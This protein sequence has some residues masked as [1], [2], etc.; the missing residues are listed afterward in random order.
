[1]SGYGGIIWALLPN[2]LVYY[3]V[4]DGG[5]ASWMDAVLESAK[6]TAICPPPGDP[7]EMNK[8]AANGMAARIFLAFLATAGLFYVN[9]MP[10]I[11]DG[12]I[13]ALGFTNQQAGAVGSANMYGAAFG[14]LAIVF[15]VRRL[16]WRRA[17][18]AALLI[19]LI[20]LDLRSLI[21][22]SPVLLTP[23][24]FVHGLVGGMLV[25]TAFS[26]IARTSQPDRTFGVLLFV[27]FGLGGLGVMF[28]PGLVPVFG[29]AILFL[30]LVA[31]SL[32]S[33]LMLTFLPAYA[34]VGP[35]PPSL[36]NRAAWNLP[37]VLALTALFL[38]QAANM[39]LY[40]F[41]IGLGEHYGLQQSFITNT[42]GPAAW[43]GLAGALF[44]I[45]VG[46]R[47]GRSL[48]LVLGI[49]LTI[50]GTLAFLYS[51]LHWVWITANLL[52]G[53]TWAFTVS[54]LLGLVASFD[55]LGQ[56]AAMGGF[57][58]K[59]GLASGPALFAVV[60]GE[61]Q[62]ALI[63]WIAAAALVGCLLAVLLPARRQ[64]HLA[65]APGMAPD[66]G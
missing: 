45:L 53:I 30:S 66:A 64:D 28:I 4:N 32:V 50:I 23:L 37:L 52:I 51:N 2:G 38:F 55:K 43:V 19:T 35:P 3:H 42:L 36:L 58:S 59:L 11:M 27:Q 40:A 9:I 63:I 31:F 15:L 60:L 26:V 5:H 14:A 41:I 65:Q 8:V 16:N 25:G 44:V 47:F 57:A 17:A 7:P 24:R 21:M 54:Y 49:G 39:G 62:Y 29:T 56:M 10:A 20:A 46:N 12:L 22:T 61:N 6:L 33:L 1:M 13:E 48:P 34:L 18:L